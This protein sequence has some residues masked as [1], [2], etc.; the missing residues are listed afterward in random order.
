MEFL[1]KGMLQ[2]GAVAM[3]TAT[4]VACGGS[5]GG[6]GGMSPPPAAT[7]N[8][9]AGIA[10]MVAM[11]LTANVSLSGSVTTNGV[12]TPFT[13]TGTYTLSKGSSATFNGTAASA[14]MESLSGTITAA[15][16]SSPLST[17][18]T[19]YYATSS[20]AFLG[21]D[22]GTEFDVAQTPFDWPTS[23]TGASGGPLGTVLRYTDKT[24][25]V[26]IGKADVTYSVLSPVD[27]GSQIGI[28][29]TTKIY[30]G[31]T[32]LVETDTT[33]YT[34]TSANVISFAGA[35][36]QSSSGSLTVTTQ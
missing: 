23:I 34:M 24:M 36:A 3:I 11:G 33:K 14:Q 20:S 21:Q 4:L 22:E 29:L 1:M 9:Q 15:G 26:S 27:P 2:A 5:N 16:Q 10:N 6:S 17:S 7:Y 32:N 18:V 28:T 35:T 12:S 30:D 19:N 31:Q 25:S 8:L 13:G